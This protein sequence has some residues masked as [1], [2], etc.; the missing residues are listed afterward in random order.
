MNSTQG[1][2][3]WAD[4][5]MSALVWV[6]VIGYA[7]THPAIQFNQPLSII[8]GLALLAVILHW[9]GGSAGLKGLVAD[10]EAVANALP[11]LAATLQSTQHAAALAAVSSSLSSGSSSLQEASPQRSA[12]SGLSALASTTPATQGG[13]ENG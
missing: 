10:L 6:S 3:A 4:V 2:G 12:P 1:R 5:I 11:Q 13:T 8:L 9:F 7:Y